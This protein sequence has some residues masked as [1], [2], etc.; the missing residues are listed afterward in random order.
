MSTRE[1]STLSAQIKSDKELAT[2]DIQT[3]NSAD[4]VVALFASLGY[5]PDAR[6]LQ[7]TAAMGI[8]AESVSRKVRRIERVATEEGGDLQVYLLE[9]DSVT[10]AATHAL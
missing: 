1:G 2:R 8:T 7:T 6:V 3:L 9:L 10:I 4:S 5:S